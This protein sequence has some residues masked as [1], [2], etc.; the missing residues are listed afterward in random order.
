MQDLRVYVSNFLANG[1]SSRK[2]DSGDYVGVLTLE[3][4]GYSV[5]LEQVFVP[6]GKDVK[7]HNGKKIG[8]TEIIVRK[9]ESKDT[10]KV[11]KMCDRLCWLM[12]L[13][14]LT[15]SCRYAYD[16]PDGQR[17]E[18]RT[19]IG[20]LNKFRPTLN[21][22]DGK[23]V[24]TYMQN[25]YSQFKKYEK[26]RDLT[27]VINYLANAHSHEMPLQFKLLGCFVVLESLKST[28]AE[29]SSI[30]FIAGSYRKGK[31]PTRKSPKYTFEE[32]VKMMLREQGLKFGL[33][34]IIKLR[35]DIVH[36]GY[37]K[38]TFKHQLT[39]FERINDILRVYLLSLLN[40]EGEYPVYSKAN[41]FYN[42]I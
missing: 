42:E 36:T 21:L 29:N 3:V 14:G 7:K 6:I 39:Q 41:S 18:E 13:A 24:Q 40:Y 5:E 10:K 30:P 2:N 38:R 26:A 37:T 17:R 33:R 22:E 16:Y 1:A 11:L 19:V 12:T 4:D 8:T 35:N 27:A 9:V 15:M 25:G 31:N 23:S 32:L 28:F 34:R 20:S